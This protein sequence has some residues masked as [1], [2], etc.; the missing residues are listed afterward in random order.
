LEKKHKKT[1]NQK[2]RKN[3]RNIQA[4]TAAIKEDH[5]SKVWK[6]QRKVKLNNTATIIEKHLLTLHIDGCNKEG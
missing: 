5:C 6:L 2:Q 4:I 3:I 1:L